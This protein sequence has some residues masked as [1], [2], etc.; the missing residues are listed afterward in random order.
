MK[1]DDREAL[2]VPHG[3]LCLPDWWAAGR[4]GSELLLYFC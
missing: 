4:G 1:S 2:R 3:G